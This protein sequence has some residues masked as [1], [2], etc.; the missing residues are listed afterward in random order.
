[1]RIFAIA[2]CI[3]FTGLIFSSSG[4]QR[5]PGD[6]GSSLAI[7][8]EPLPEISGFDESG[9]PF[10]LREKFAGKHAVIVFGCLT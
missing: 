9:N 10:P 6:R 4:Q 5:Q 1:M 3:L 7:E 8:G 2:F